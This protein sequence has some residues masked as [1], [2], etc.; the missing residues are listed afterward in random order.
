MDI[1]P[2]AYFR[3]P[4]GSKFGAP[5][6][7]GLADIPGDIVFVAPYDDPN[8]LRSLEGFDYVWLIWGF[9]ANHVTSRD[10][11]PTVR[12]PRLGGN[13]QVGVFA[14]RSPFRPNPLGLSAVRITSIEPGIIHTVGADLI[15]GTPIYDVKPYLPYADAFPEARSG[16]APTA[17]SAS[18]QVAWAAPSPFSP[19]DTATIERILALDPRPAYSDDS[20]KVYGFPFAGRDIRFTVSGGTATIIEVAPQR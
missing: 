12:P 9:S 13:S 3:S 11:S 10:W 14:S 18:L 8:A 5:R 15:D 7:S 4:L 16:F 19:E 20:A 2:V 1:K 6:Q 17:P